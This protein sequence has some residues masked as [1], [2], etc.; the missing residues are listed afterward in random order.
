M[1]ESMASMIPNGTHRCVRTRGGAWAL[2]ARRVQ[3]EGRPGLLFC[4]ATDLASGAE[5][6]SDLRNVYPK[7][8]QTHDRCVP[9]RPGARLRRHTGSRAV[10]LV[11]RPAPLNM[12]GPS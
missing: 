12:E 10:D 7:G 5:T 8:F 6:R 9:D 11:R 2:R 3:Q 1:R 4:T